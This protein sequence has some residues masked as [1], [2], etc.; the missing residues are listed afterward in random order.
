MIFTDLH[1]HTT[2]SDG[3]NTPEEVVLSAIDM[4]FDAIGFSGHGY[5]DFDLTYCMKD[6]NRLILDLLLTWMLT[7]FKVCLRIL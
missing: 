4:G 1:V 7:K 2:F 3:K 5:T 6:M